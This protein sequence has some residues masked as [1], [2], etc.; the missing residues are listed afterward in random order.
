MLDFYRVFLKCGITIFM[1]SKQ[2]YSAT[3]FCSNSTCRYKMKKI[4][5]QMCSFSKP[6]STYSISQ[7]QRLSKYST[8]YMSAGEE[9]WIYH[10]TVSPLSYSSSPHGSCHQK[11]RLNMERLAFLLSSE[12]SGPGADG[13]LWTV[14]CAWVRVYM[15][16]CVYM[17]VTV[18]ACSPPGDLELDS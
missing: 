7:W 8:E 14:Q 16:A 6:N 4:K 10:D 18:C 15:R 2:S 9:L 5:L 11:N 1:Q 12:V 17:S 3:G 13:L